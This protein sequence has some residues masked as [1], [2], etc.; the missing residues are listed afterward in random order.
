MN[1]MDEINFENVLEF[2]FVLLV[3]FCEKLNGFCVLNVFSVIFQK[4]FSH[5]N[6]KQVVNL[7]AS[8]TSRSYADTYKIHL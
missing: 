3:L 4:C 8:S 6:S 1:F 7:Y 2:F 5:S